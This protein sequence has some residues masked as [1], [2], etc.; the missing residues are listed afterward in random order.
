M[1]TVTAPKFEVD[2]IVTTDLFPG[3]D[4]RIGQ[5]IQMANN[6]NEKTFVLIRSIS[7]CPPVELIV[8]IDDLNHKHVSTERRFKEWRAYTFIHFMLSSIQQGIQSAHIIA[9]L[10]L[11][12]EDTSNP[13][14]G[15]WAKNHK[16][17]ITLN[18][19]NSAGLVEK[20][21]TIRKAL[22]LDDADGEYVYALFREDA[23]SLESAMTGF[24]I[25]LPDEIYDAKPVYRR[26]PY[27]KSIVYYEWVDPMT[28]E[29]KQYSIHSPA[30]VIISILQ[31]C[32]LAK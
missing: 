19:G 14:F 27:D 6:D 18:G 7:T 15:V 31:S 13:D 12:A 17:I 32:P 9:E 20:L 24:G 2:N 26:D 29:P 30:G 16:T 10:A 1:T 28:H 5:F 8:N 3:V 4:F 22:A 11:K 23:Q 25:I 21:D